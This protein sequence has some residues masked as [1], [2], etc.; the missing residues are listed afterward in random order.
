MLAGR[1]LKAGQRWE[2]NVKWWL[3]PV[4]LMSSASAGVSAD[5]TK[6][7]VSYK[8]KTVRV[9]PSPD[10]G[11]GVTDIRVVLHSDGTVDDSYDTKFGANGSSKSRLGRK[12]ANAGYSVINGNTL[13]RVDGNETYTHKLTITVNGKNCDAKIERALKKGHALFRAYNKPLKTDA[14]Y[15]SIE[16]EYTTCVIE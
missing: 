3:V 4:L 11:G 6:I 14:Y 15:S 13:V 8:T 1:F 2:I 12:S 9:K 5:D 7:F 16:N 10:V